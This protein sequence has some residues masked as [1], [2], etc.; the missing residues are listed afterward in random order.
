VGRA[1]PTIPL[2]ILAAAWAGVLVRP[3]ARGGVRLVYRVAG[4]AAAAHVVDRAR[5][6]GGTAHALDGIVVVDVPDARAMED[7]ASASLEVKLVLDGTPAMAELGRVARSDAQATARGVTV[8][9]DSWANETTNA[10]HTD[11]YLRGPTCAALRDYLAELFAARPE[12]QPSE[13]DLVWEPSAGP[14]GVS[15]RSYLVRR[16]AELSAADVADAQI[17]YDPT[18]NRP[19]V[20]LT[21]D[22]R[23][24]RRFAEVTA[25]NV[26]RKLAILVDGA[27][28]SAPEIRT[29][30]P[31]GRATISLGA[32]DPNEMLMEAEDLVASVRAGALGAGVKLKSTVPTPPRF[33][34][35]EATLLR[36]GAA[37]LAGVVAFLL[38][39]RFI[40]A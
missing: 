15:C 29:E 25:A 23:G 26:G 36:A 14:D 10:E 20:L 6:R 37:V 21:F 16:R 24:R 11:T 3:D 31:G 27:V 2:S 13:G 18:T 39:R 28:T 7:V 34:A 8:G 9:I 19:E 33:T 32:R 12:L 5:R 38:A 17:W 22:A 35:T 40:H 1:F 30:I 4:Q